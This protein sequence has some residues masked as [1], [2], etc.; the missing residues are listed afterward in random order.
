LSR[1]L[2]IRTGFPLA[3]DPHGTSA[4]ARGRAFDSNKEDFDMKCPHCGH[5]DGFGNVDEEP[6]TEDDHF[7]KLPIKME[8]RGYDRD[9]KRVYACPK[10]LKV[11]IDRY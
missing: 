8:R 11:F 6:K 2:T 7:Y 3:A 5:S 4:V 9:E 1:S 10:C